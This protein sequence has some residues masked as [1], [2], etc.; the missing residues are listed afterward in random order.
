LNFLIHFPKFK[1]ILENS[2]DYAIIDLWSKY[3]T[4]IPYLAY[5]ISAKDALLS[6]DEGHC[7]I[8]LQSI[9]QLDL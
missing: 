8:I 6:H 7:L 5:V 1:K 2:G 9:R 3:Q 4:L